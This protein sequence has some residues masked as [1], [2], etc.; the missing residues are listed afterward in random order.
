MFLNL[1]SYIKFDHKFQF[2]Y[3]QNQ[4]FYLH[5]EIIN[6]MHLMKQMLNNYFQD[7]KLMNNSMFI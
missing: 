4:F 3:F 7:Q 5:Y 6:L 1:S 2:Q